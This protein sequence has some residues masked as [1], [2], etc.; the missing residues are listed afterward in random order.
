ML[1]KG[2]DMKECLDHMS[3]ECFQFGY[4]YPNANEVKKMNKD[5]RKRMRWVGFVEDRRRED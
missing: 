4:A 1:F 5:L 3:D 2:G